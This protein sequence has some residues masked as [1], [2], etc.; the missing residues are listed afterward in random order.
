MGDDMNNLLFPAGSLKLA[1]LLPLLMSLP[2]VSRGAG[3]APAPHQPNVLSPATTGLLLEDVWPTLFFGEEAIA[4]IARKAKTLP[5]AQEAVAT[6]QREAEAV[7]AQPPQLPV[8]AAGWRHDFYSRATAEHLQYDLASP[9]RYRDPLTGQFEHDPAQHRAWVLLTHERTFRLMRGVGV[10]YC[11]TGDERYARWVADGMRQAASYYTHAEFRRQDISG[12]ALYFSNLY[13]AA[14]LT[15]LANACSLTQMSAAYSPEDKEKIR[16]QIFE[17]RMPT[18]IEFLRVRPTHNMSCF[19][20]LAL[21]YAGKLFE[22]PDWSALALGETTG[23]RRQLRNGIP[24]DAHG[25][26]D[27]FWYEGTTFYHFYSLCPLVGLWE[28]DRACAGGVAVDAEM[29]RRYGKMFAA[30]VTVVDR[31][32]RLPLVGDLGAPR[33]MN[34]ASY[35]HL[36]EYAAGQV[37][38]AQFGPV[39]SAIY[40]SSGLPRNGLTALAYGPDQLPAPGGIPTSSTCLPVAGLGVFR[41]AGPEQLY[42]TFRCGK[43]VGGHDHPDRLTVALNAFGQPLSPDLGEP[44]YSLRDKANLSYYRT[45]L[46][47]NTLFADEAEQTGAAALVW[48]P[49]ATPARAQ[50]TIAAAGIRFRRTLIVDAPYVILLDDYQAAAEHRYGWVFHAYGPVTVSAPVLTAGGGPAFGMPAFPER[51]GFAH[52]HERRIGMANGPFQARWQVTKDLGLMAAMVS[53]GDLEVTAA[54]AP[55]QPYPDTLGAL[56]LRLPG[57]IRRLATV[58]EPACGTAPTMTHVALE[59]PD[60]LVTRTDGTPRRY[61]WGE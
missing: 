56:V 52:L 24:A 60:L 35:R 21:G 53:D 27:G 43:Y 3:A 34:L 40:A 23:L 46:G 47:H 17:E 19:V 14:M 16:R 11:L 9:E 5:W 58:L 18:M 25:E 2:A 50:G 8:E 30:P 44:G 28:L 6:M 33:V 45:T 1:L 51:P 7:M 32:L 39:L 22:R 57:K 49:E 20:S 48:Q 59:G 61:A 38:P 55:G 54:T 37:D 41:T 31:Q 13:D 12:P 4:E 26:V 42:V 15:L 36:Y 29:R 10:L